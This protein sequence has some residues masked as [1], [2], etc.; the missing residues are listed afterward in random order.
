MLC[1]N[2]EPRIKEISPTY[3]AGLIRDKRRRVRF[4]LEAQVVGDILQEE[5]ES[6][7]LP[8]RALSRYPCVCQANHAVRD[9]VRT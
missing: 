2:D 8:R 6:G 3:L 5:N 1:R 9:V 7:S 4:R